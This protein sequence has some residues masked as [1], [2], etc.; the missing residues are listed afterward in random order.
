[1][2]GA[3]LWDDSGGEATEL[4]DVG[5]PCLGTID[6]IREHARSLGVDTVVVVS[7]SRSGSEQLRSLA[8]R[9]EGSGIDLLVSPGLLEVSGR[10]LHIESAGWMSF[11][12]VEQPE[13]HGMRRLLKGAF[14]RVVA[15]VAL[16]VLLPVFA[17]LY[18]AIRLTSPGPAIFGQI[19]I[20]RDG[21]PFKMFKFRSMHVDAESRL[22]ALQSLNLHKSGPLFKL[23]DD[24][25]VTRIGRT[26]RRY[27]LDELPQLVNVLLGQMSLVGPRPPLPN[28]VLAYGPEARRRLLVKPGLTGLWQV[29]GRSDLDWTESL[30]L[31]LRYVE[32]WSPAL[33]LAI[34]WR[35][36]SAVLRGTGAY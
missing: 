9:L 26:L 14:D 32:N 20:G 6:S 33:D 25:R 31:D 10:R 5:V 2:L 19:R 36:A 29:S 8:W 11:L 17:V 3:C 7:S 12:A 23:R 35:T 1:V 24:P 27:S 18:A 13:F 4:A 22:T 34:L 15:L 21:K 30:R 28:E 16:L